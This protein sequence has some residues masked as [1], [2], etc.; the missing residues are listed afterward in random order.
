MIKLLKFQCHCSNLTSGYSLS[1]LRGVASLCVGPEQL[2]VVLQK[3]A[4]GGRDTELRYAR[5]LFGNYSATHCPTLPGSICASTQ[6]Q[7]Y[8][9]QALIRSASVSLRFCITCQYCD[10]ARTYL[11]ENIP[12]ELSTGTLDLYTDEE[13]PAKC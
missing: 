11:T 3:S 4:L 10:L 12:P 7:L 2:P 5:H 13:T 8:F 1:P 9:P 6:R